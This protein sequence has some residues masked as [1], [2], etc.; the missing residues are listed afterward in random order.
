M[1]AIA[2]AALALSAIAYTILGIRNFRRA[3]RLRDHLPISDDGQARVDGATEFSA[4]TVAATVSLATVILAFTELASFFGLWLLWTAITT[5]VGLVVLRIAAPIIWRQVSAFGEQRPTLHG[6]LGASY[7]SPM[8]IRA[9]ALCTSAGF[10]GAMAVELTVGSRFLASMVPSIDPTSAVFLLSAV[11]VGYTMLGGFRVVIQTDRIQM[12]V[13]WLAIAALAA[14]VVILASNGGGVIAAIN[15]AP[16]GIFDFGWREGLTP[17]L[18]GIAI[19]NIP[20]FMADMSVWQRI[21]GARKEEAVD[22]GVTRSV[23]GAL[24]SWSL[25]AILA[26]FVASLVKAIPET[27]PLSTF[28]TASHALPGL[29]A[30]V[31]VF[32]VIAGLYAAALSTASTQL[33]AA[34]ATIH[35]DLLHRHGTLAP[36]DTARELGLARLMVVALGVASIAIVE[37]LRAAGFSIADLVFALYGS[38]LGLT[39]VVL[40]ALAGNRERNAGRGVWAA[41]AVILGF[42]AGWGVAFYGKWAAD[43][44]LVFLAPLASLAISSF[45]CA[46]GL[47]AAKRQTVA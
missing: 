16:A 26:C 31:L 10:L 29:L 5:A 3:T 14:L 6:F 2:I 17:F 23:M 47:F 1:E 27:N 20:T 24:V 36:A 11:G 41:A 7:N 43:S 22:R 38:Q 44:N 30:S 15:H 13:I 32:V 25:L 8:L 4:A 34:G 35:I 9:A 19:I 28:L 40:I 37:L 45:I 21:A 46:G 18:I 33:I 39:P 12:I 42:L